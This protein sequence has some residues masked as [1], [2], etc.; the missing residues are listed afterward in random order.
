MANWQPVEYERTRGMH[1]FI[2]NVFANF[3]KDTLDYLSTCLYPRFEYRVVGTYEKAIEYITKKS[4][5]GREVD[6]PITPALILNPSGDFELADAIAGGHQLWRF[7]FLAPGLGRRFYTPVYQDSNMQVTVGFVRIQ[8]DIELLMLLN[9]MYE[10]L[11][12][13]MMLMQVF[14]GMDRWIYPRFFNTFI[15]LPPEI[16]NFKY[17]NE[18]TGESYRI[19]WYGAGAYREV[20][21][22]TSINELV[23]P[24]EVKPLYKLTSFN[25]A[26][27][28]LGGVD[29]LPEWKLGAIIRYEIELPCWLIIN[30]DYIVQNINAEIRAGSSYSVYDYDVPSNRFSKDIRYWWGLDST[31]N[32]DDLDILIGDSTCVEG[33]DIEYALNTRYYHVVTA[34]EASSTTDVTISIPEQITDIK[35]LILNSRYGEMTYGDHYVLTN[36][37]N[38]V[39]IKIDDVELVEGMIIELYV[40]TKLE[41]P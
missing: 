29:K 6:V 12:V 5:L 23:I 11:D 15:V 17:S 14:G 41:R 26:S 1:F 20:L 25:D 33:L 34:G 13:K 39:K 40:Y 2:H 9:S 16:A 38:S 8:G 37:G 35:L 27:A 28:R 36:N 22:T 30:T 18:Y 7:P 10:Y 24:A 31:S 19:D 21:K 3:Y 4:Q 32:I